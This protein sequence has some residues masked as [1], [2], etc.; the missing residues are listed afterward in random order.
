MREK[1]TLD[2]NR[3]LERVSQGIGAYMSAIERL[4]PQALGKKKMSPR[5][6]KRRFGLGVREIEELRRVYGDS[7]FQEILPFLEGGENART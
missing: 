4:G 3:V 7:A 5:Q 2:M 6:V 1:D